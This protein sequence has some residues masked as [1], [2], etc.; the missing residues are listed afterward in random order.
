MQ[1]LSGIIK[2]SI[3][4]HGIEK[5]VQAAMVCCAWNKL[6][7]EKLGENIGG[8]SSAVSFRNG[9]L[10]VAALGSVY[11]QEIEMNKCRFLQEINQQFKMELIER[12]RIV[13][14]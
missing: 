1:K 12:V 2:K 6:I 7:I 11:A 4:M 14:R 3:A 8:K 10:K 5:Q 9:T 13:L